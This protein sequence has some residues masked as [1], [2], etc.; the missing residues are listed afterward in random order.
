[1]S[2]GLKMHSVS[3][4]FITF[5]PSFLSSA[6][7]TP[8]SKL[9]E[10]QG[11]IIL[12]FA[13]KLCVFQRMRSLLEDRIPTITL[14]AQRSLREESAELFIR[15]TCPKH[16]RAC[17]W[18]HRET[19]KHAHKWKDTSMLMDTPRRTSAFFCLFWNIPRGYVM[20]GLW[21]GFKRRTKLSAF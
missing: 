3:L 1:M 9:T 2:Y 12:P 14:R 4:Y 21:G 6:L 17:A 10:D 5:P 13:W 15:L 19:Q 18:I 20:E 11:K 7:T 8:F 16:T